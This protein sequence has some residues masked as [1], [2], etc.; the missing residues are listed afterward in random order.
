MKTGASHSW[1]NPRKPAWKF[2]MWSKSTCSQKWKK[3]E[4][5]TVHTE[6]SLTNFQYEVHPVYDRNWNAESCFEK[7][8]KSKMHFWRVFSFVLLLP[9][10]IKT[11]ASS[12]LK[13]RWFLKRNLNLD[14]KSV[15][16][17]VFHSTILFMGPGFLSNEM[18]AMV[19]TNAVTHLEKSTWNKISLHCARVARLKMIN[20][21]IWSKIIQ[22]SKG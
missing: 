10:R 19:A 3:S 2:R 18:W 6:Y 1:I 4:K 13:S 17:K 5:L 15:I 8:V 16:D 20:F 11:E 9:T 21:T 22:L 7:I 14:Y 12:P